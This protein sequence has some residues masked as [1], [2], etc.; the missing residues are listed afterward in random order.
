MS[1]LLLTTPSTFKDLIRRDPVPIMNAL[2]MLSAEYVDLSQDGLGNLG[3]SELEKVRTYGLFCICNVFM[4][5]LCSTKNLEAAAHY[6]KKASL[7]YTEF[8]SQI[9]QD[10]NSFLRL[11]PTDAILFTYKKTIFTADRELQAAIRPDEEGFMKRI[12]QVHLVIRAY[13]VAQIR[14]MWVD[15]SGDFAREI[16]RLL[17]KCAENQVSTVLSGAEEIVYALDGMSCAEDVR[18]QLQGL[19]V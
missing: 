4:M 6:G 18:A 8:I 1:T 19:G 16:T 7:Y 3:K 15:D 9:N 5:V 17:F 11:T 13:F 12:F 2:S 10:G 14:G